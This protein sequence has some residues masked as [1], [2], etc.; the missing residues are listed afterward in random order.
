M[1]KAF[2]PL[3]L[4][5][6]VLIT[7]A[8]ASSQGVKKNEKPGILLV[9]FGSSEAR[10]QASFKNI[11]AKTREAFPNTPVF[12]AYTSSVIRKKMADQGLDLD[13]P[14]TA[15][16]KMADQGFTR[17]VVQSLHTIGG[18]EYGELK[19]IVAGF[20]AMG[21]F[22]KI[23]LGAPLLFTQADMERTVDAILKTIPRSRKAHEAV[24]L[25][26]HGTHHPANA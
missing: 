13:A 5:V 9:A 24:V 6:L 20:D 2:F 11:E 21:V 23:A 15:L 18:S 3:L 17:V 10:A 25:M 14:Q 16:S 12:W 19:R 1:K 7:P 22:R 26:G 8:L 4:C